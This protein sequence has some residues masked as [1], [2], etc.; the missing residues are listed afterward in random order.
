M[1]PVKWWKE[2]SRGRWRWVFPVGTLFGEVLFE[3]GGDQ[4][5]YAFEIRTRKRY[6]DGW[7][8]DVF[9]PF[10]TAEAF[11]QGIIAK[12]PDW[13]MS[14]DLANYIRNLRN[15]GTLVQNRW[16][17]KAYGNA[18]TPID[19][20][21]DKLPEFPDASLLSDLLTQTQ[22]VSAEGSIWKENGNLQ[23]Y[24]PSSTTD[25]NIVPK[26]Y[27]MGMVPVNEVSCTRCHSEV[28]RRLLD[29][30]FDIQLYGEVWGEDRIFTWHLFEPHRYIYG[31]W[32]D[33]D[34]NSRTLNIRM[35][36]AQLVKNEKPSAGNP[37][38]KMLPSAYVPELKTRSK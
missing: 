34:S 37:L 31:P 32:D 10:V 35:N 13:Q 18:F 33:S 7:S 23:T 28:G 11:A 4:K 21:L 20:A 16:E 2:S 24:A 19:G 8:V 17:S 30:E 5:W 25:F 36:Q 27:E 12:R 1:L 26:G 22:F 6:L 9:R 3:K 15:T 14:V 29:F 38:Y